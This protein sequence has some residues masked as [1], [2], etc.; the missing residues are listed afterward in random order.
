MQAGDFDDLLPL[1]LNE[2]EDRLERLAELAPRV[3]TDEEAAAI[4]KRELHALKGASRMMG[5]VDMSD[6]CHDAETLLETGGP[7]LVAV[8]V[9]AVDGLAGLLAE[10]RKGAAPDQDS[11]PRE[12]AGAPRGAVPLPLPSQTQMRVGSAVLD[13]LA[14]R[15][16]RMRVLAVAAG[17]VKDRLFELSRLAERGVADDS[18]EQVLATLASLLRQAAFELEGGERRL[19]RLVDRQLDA[20]V[21]LQLQPLKPFLIAAGRHARD[22]AQSLGK[23]VTVEVSTE[24]GQLDRRVLAAIG[25]V[26]LHL[27]RNAVDHGI[28]PA[29][30]RTAAGKPVIA[31]LRLVCVGA[32]ERVRLEIEDDGRGID[33]KHV[34]EA[35]LA[36]GLIGD[37]EASS[38]GPDDALRLLFR[39]GFT[40]R[41]TAGEVSGRGVGLDAVAEAVRGV[42]GD[43]LLASEPGRA[44]RVTLL[45]P[46]TRHADRLLVVSAAG[47][48]VGL[49]AAG[50]TAYRHVPRGSG[51]HVSL[52][53]G[54]SPVRSLS[55]MLAGL[56]GRDEVV[57]VEASVGGVELALAVD[58]VVGEEEVVLR[59]LPRGLGAP[60]CFTEMALLASGRPVPVVSLHQLVDRA[61][62]RS[63]AGGVRQPSGPVRVLLVDD[64]RVTREMLRRVLEDGGFEVT[65]LGA[66]EEALRALEDG[67]FDCVVT[68]IEMP[69]MNGLELTRALRK[70]PSLA[71]LPVVVVSTRNRPED[72]HAGLAAGADAYLAKQGLEARELLAV[73]AR[74]G[75]R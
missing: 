69:G 38:L 22:L 32:G 5:L 20:L 39:P 57:V 30:E 44:T 46:V 7:E 40:T 33:P 18:P 34:V 60:A 42:G 55:E 51:E 70:T 35:A 9:A 31:T 12:L 58:A 59:V 16:S 3:G 75:A 10:R 71:Q 41:E 74:L 68:D 27:V 62:G 24:S 2:A 29:A 73:I 50:V 53:Q 8:L 48:Q 17:G 23:E 37:E 72:H 21:G 43:V 25:E 13:R 26:V 66:A 52:L 4:V 47:F 28:E 6:R 49:P 14:D 61:A 45:L 11:A 56:R 1:F 64:S 19:R 54:S 65:S 63:E 36:Q 67:G 15:A